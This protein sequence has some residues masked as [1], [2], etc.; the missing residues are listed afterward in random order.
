MS[1]CRAQEP[2]HMQEGSSQSPTATAQNPCWSQGFPSRRLTSECRLGSSPAPSSSTGVGAASSALLA[3]HPER[4]GSYLWHLAGCGRRDWG[5]KPGADFAFVQHHLSILE[6]GKLMMMII[7]SILMSTCYGPGRG[8][9][10]CIISFNPQIICKVDRIISPYF[11][12]A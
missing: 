10:T 4:A 7:Y 2:M 5:G 11:S 6:L 1:G 9:Y 12:D 3:G 8:L